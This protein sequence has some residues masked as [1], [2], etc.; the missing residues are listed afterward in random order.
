MSTESEEDEDK[1]EDDTRT[2]RQRIEDGRRMFQ[3][4]AARLLE[5]RVMTAY[6]EKVRTPRFSRLSRCC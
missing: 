2:E 6:Q 5:Q 1:L 3:M 4:V